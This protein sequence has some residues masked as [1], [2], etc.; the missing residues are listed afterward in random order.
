MIIDYYHKDGS[1]RNLETVISIIRDEADKPVGIQG[2]SRDITER[3]QAEEELQ[4]HRE[5]LEELIKERTAELENANK[6]LKR[7]NKLFEGREFRIKELKDKVK[8]LEKELRR[9]K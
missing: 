6:E 4:K 3:K 5:H 2:L 9:K 1:V 7:Y 8:E